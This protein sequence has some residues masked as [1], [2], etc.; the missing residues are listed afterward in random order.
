M[1]SYDPGVP[2]WVDV[3]S[4]DLPATVGFYKAL[5]GWDSFEPPGGGGYTIFQQRGKSVAAAGPAM[6]PNAPEAWTTYVNVTDADATAEAVKDAGGTVLA[7]PFDVLTAGRMGVFMDDGG[8][9]FSAWQPRDTIG[10]QL[11][12]EPVSLAWNELASNDIEKSKAFYAKVF[13]WAAETEQSGPMSYTEFKLKGRS[14]AGM[15][16]IGAM[17]P[18]GTPPYWLVYFAVADTDATVARTSELGGRTFA[19]PMDIPIGRF[20]VLA[21][22]RGAAFGV[23]QLAPR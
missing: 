22:A 18:A 4:R 5:F 14:I 19:P 16:Q 17:V 7:G 11:T 1:T 12:S 20:A 21:D 15:A 2:S 9:V 23:V 13:G 6:D 8:A 3:S 10:A